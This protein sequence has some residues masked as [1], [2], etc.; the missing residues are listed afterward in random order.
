MDLIRKSYEL[1]Y[2]DKEFDLDAILIY[3]GKFSD[4]NANARL[5]GKKLEIKLC[6]KWEN[7]SEEI[8][9]G[10]IQELLIRI[11]KTKKTSMYMDIYN[12]FLK[13]IHIAIP[14]TKSH[15]LLEESFNRINE[16][17]FLGLVEQPNLIWGVESK[18]KLG[19]YNFK[20]DEILISKVFLKL[21]PKFLDLVMYH[22][23]LHKQRKFESKNGRERYHDRV[24]KEREKLF[25]NSELL[26][27]ELTKKLRYLKLKGLFFD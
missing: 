11:L 3:S 16:R 13:N 15:P 23:V 26:E 17:Y 9:I 4:Y 12:H 19:H 21:D 27:K 25:E 10:L 8:K 20:K 22:E 6:R 1:L 24:F 7:V 2:P 5:K 18:R 14:K